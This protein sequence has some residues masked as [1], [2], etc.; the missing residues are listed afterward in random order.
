MASDTRLVVKSHG[1]KEKAT[2]DFGT[3]QVQILVLKTAN[4]VALCDTLDLY[5]SVCT[6]AEWD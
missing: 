2:L 3:N 1:R 4:R 6:A 5:K